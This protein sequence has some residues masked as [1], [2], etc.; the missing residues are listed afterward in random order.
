MNSNLSGY[1]RGETPSPDSGSRAVPGAPL[2]RDAGHLCVIDG[3]NMLH[4][5][6]AMARHRTRADGL[7]IAAADLFARMMHKLLRRML[8]GRYPPSHVAVFFDP[9]RGESWRRRIYPDYKIDRPD[10]DPGL[11]AQTPLM[12]SA[13]ECMG[14]S[15]AVAPRHEADD[16]IAAYVED[17][18]ATGARCSIVSTDKDLMQLVR[19]R[20]L[21]LSPVRE[22]WYDRDRV[23]RKFGVCPD[24][25][26]DFLALSGDRCDGIPGAPGIGPV[27][28]CRIL[29]DFG[30]LGAVLRN[31]EALAKPAWRRA[32]SENMEMIQLSRVL[33]SLDHEAAP[34]L[35]SEED[36]RAPDIRRVIDGVRAWRN[37]NLS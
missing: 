29:S 31:P 8:S 17:A 5:A 7:D 9:P 2:R 16:L 30:S 33:V 14:V 10:T 27:S 18:A 23:R 34:R 11:V 3:S 36:M 32:V 12:R 24:R 22:E 6:W 20:V 25:L 21:Q 15:S 19:P 1:T 35:L 37:D 4:R 13:C 28:A 26:A